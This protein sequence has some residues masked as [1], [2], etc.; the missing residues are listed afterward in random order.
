MALHMLKLSVGTQSIESLGIFQAQRL[1]DTGRTFHIT[2]MVPRRKKELLDGG[3]I[4]WVIRGNILARQ[5]LI[6]IEEFTDRE[7][8][9]RC[10]LVFEPPL[11]PVRP[12]PRRPFQGWRYFKPEDVPPDL[13]KAEQA[14]SM[15]EQMR[16]E[17]VELGLL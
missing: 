10:R 9:R 5:K 8:I 14:G 11:I 17:L 1:K 7:E 12:V 13:S 3:S 4:Y 6:D 16:A 15:S 2:R